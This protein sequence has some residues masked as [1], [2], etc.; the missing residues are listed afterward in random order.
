MYKSSFV[1]AVVL[2][3]VSTVGCKFSTN[4]ELLINVKK[5][6]NAV[7]ATAPLLT[8]VTAIGLLKDNNQPS[9]TFNSSQE[10]TIQ[11]S[12]DCNAA[13]TAAMQGDNTITFSTLPWDRAY[14]NCQLTVTN[15]DN[16]TSAPLVITPFT[17]IK[18]VTLND[19]GITTCGN[20]PLIEGPRPSGTGSSVHD[21]N[22]DC[23]GYVGLGPTDDG[24]DDNGET[25]PPGQDLMFG[26]DYDGVTN[27]NADGV[28]G[29]SFTKL[30]NSG[31]DMGASSSGWRCVRDNVTGLIWEAKQVAPHNAGDK[32]TWYNSDTSTNAGNAGTLNTETSCVGYSGS[33]P[34][35]YCNTEAYINRINAMNLCGYNDWRLPAREELLSLSHK[36]QT[37]PAI[38]PTFFSDTLFAPG[39]GTNFYWTATSSVT[40]ATEARTVSFRDGK[41]EQS[42]KSFALLVRLVRGDY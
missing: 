31:V 37:N 24:V 11:Y 1:V 4:A 39:T 2:L 12:G 33:D 16:E 36:G 3:S 22:I 17:L 13:V 38:D 32:F 23:L 7:S 8:E 42:P 6:K 15:V 26:R 9:Y 40:V 28:A 29:F 20:Y 25:I 21:N 14:N 34:A 18:T 10:G 5:D 19:T 27:D 35:S 30:N 41:E